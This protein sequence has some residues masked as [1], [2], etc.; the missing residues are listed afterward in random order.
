MIIEMITSGFD[1][2]M[3]MLQ[4]GGVITYIIL[5]L[6]IYGLLISIRKIFY[7]RKISKIDATEIMGTITSSMEQGGAIEALKK[8]WSKSSLLSSQE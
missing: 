3:E 5:L 1:I 7:L 6:G 8:V 4:S 2:I